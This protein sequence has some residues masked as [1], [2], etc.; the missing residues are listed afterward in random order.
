MYLKVIFFLISHHCSFVLN[1]YKDWSKIEVRPLAIIPEVVLLPADASVTLYCGGSIQNWSY[2][3][4]FFPP[5]ET[6]YLPFTNL[7]IATKYT[8]DLNKLTLTN[9]SPDDSGFYSCIGQYHNIS[10]RL[11]SNL[12]VV[13]KIVNGMVV[14]SRVEVSHGSSVTLSCGSIRPVKWT[15][16][17][18][19]ETTEG[20]LTLRN[21]KKKD[22]G[23]YLCRGVNAVGDVF[24]DFAIVIVDGWRQFLN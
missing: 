13:D 23:R 24:H 7:S 15:S 6:Y 3:G 9:L 17:H 4:I 11:S 20:T 21:L 19:S 22:S 16:T 5:Q 18:F 14:P 10:Y 1:I 12:I 8:V 2:S